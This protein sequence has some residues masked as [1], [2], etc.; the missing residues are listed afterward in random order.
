MT[1]IFGR[2]ICREDLAAYQKFIIFSEEIKMG[3]NIGKN[4]LVKS[5]SEKYQIFGH[6]RKFIISSEGSVTER[7]YFDMFRKEFQNKRISVHIKQLDPKSSSPGYVLGE[8]KNYLKKNSFDN[9]DEAWLVMDKDRWTDEQLGELH[10]WSLKA[11]N[12]HLAV[13]NPKF[14]Y[15]L[16][17]HFEDAGGIT[18]SSCGDKLEKYLPGYRKCP[19]TGKFS[20]DNIKEAVGRARQKDRDDAGNP[21]NWPSGNGSTVYRLVE[22]LIANL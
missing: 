3:K 7:V 17:L 1:K 8:M 6:V 9:N 11:D 5:R 15:W 20:I 2:V 16:L 14:E 21:E 10:R 4:R 12:Y 18:A 19:D 22:K 13:S